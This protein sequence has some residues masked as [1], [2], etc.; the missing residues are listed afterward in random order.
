MA[1]PWLPALLALA[2]AAG[3]FGPSHAP[4]ADRGADQRVEP[5][6]VRFIA[7]GDMGTGGEDQAR[8]AN[9]IGSVCSLRGCDFAVGLGDL[10]YPAGTSSA[11]DPQ[12]DEKFEVPYR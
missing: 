11:T 12:F 9:A 10:I 5:A 8:V 4:A 2:L 1:R 7:L 6:R 3:C